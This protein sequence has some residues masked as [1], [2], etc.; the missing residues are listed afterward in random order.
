MDG[1]GDG[2]MR[3]ERGGSSVCLREAHGAG[4]L[5][6]QRVTV[7][8]T[9]PIAITLCTKAECILRQRRLVV[10]VWR[11]E[12]QAHTA[13]FPCKGDDAFEQRAPE[14]AAGSGQG[15]SREVLEGVWLLLGSGAG[16]GSSVQKL[17]HVSGFKY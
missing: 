16:F 10:C 11:K 7:R 14:L 13:G 1:R 17:N 3:A 2:V 15:S 4:R 12:G 8:L 5:V 6:A 9:A